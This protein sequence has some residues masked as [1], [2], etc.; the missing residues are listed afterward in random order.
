MH[1]YR[2]LASSRVGVGFMA[3]ERVL[4]P[5]A[6]MYQGDLLGGEMAL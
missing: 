1:R 6:G 4:E 5:V 3:A 2:N